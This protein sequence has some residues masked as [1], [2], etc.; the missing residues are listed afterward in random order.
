MTTATSAKTVQVYRIYIKATK[1]AVWDAITKPEWTDR[2]G[3]GG[4]TDYDL[5]PGAAYQTHPSDAMVKAGEEMGY[6]TPDVIVDGEVVE[7]DP[8]NRLVVTWRM[9]MDPG[10]AAEGFTTVT[11]EVK[12][13]ASGGVKLTVAHDVTGAPGIGAMIEGNDEDKGAGGG[14]AWVLSDL[15]SLLETGATLGA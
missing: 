1:Q 8:P 10:L 15:K 6:P 4:K 12:E 13:V 14:W 2:Y 5:K 9:L 7:A 3:Y 11:W